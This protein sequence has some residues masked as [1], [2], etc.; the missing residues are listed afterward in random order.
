[1]SRI[2]ILVNSVYQL[3]TA[4]HL[5]C[6]L[7]SDTHADILL[8]DVLPDA[9]ARIL[10][11]QE[12]ALFSRVLY[13]SSASFNA[14]Y[15]NASK[16][17]LDEVFLQPLTTLNTLISEPLTSYDSIFFSNFDPFL[18][19]IA[20]VYYSA[21]C[22]FFC[23]E[24]GF[25]S[26]V[27]SFLNPKR[28][29]I[30]THPQAMKISEKLRAFYLFE[31][32]LAMRGDSV[33]NR[34]IPKID[35]QNHSFVALLN[36]IFSYTPPP[37]FPDFL[38]LEQSFRAERIQTNDAELMAMCKQFASPR[39]FFIKPHPRCEDDMFY[40]ARLFSGSAP[41]ELY[42]LNG[43]YRHTTLLTVCSNGALSGRIALGM[44][45]EIVLLYKLF[46]GKV[47][48]KEDDVLKRYLHAFSR[49][50]PDAHCY[51][52]NTSHELEDI[53]RVLGGN[54]E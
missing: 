13:A 40:P 6:T 15:A 4:V 12:S 44:Q 45:N 23:Y 47:L 9:R 26:Y 21:P 11:L 22:D 5:K 17:S 30:N 50:F 54:N 42:L 29:V 27:I 52:P 32:T 3:L 25:S 39:R 28:A 24:D 43:M 19:L 8:T 38:F 7:L 31:P 10:P 49:R 35:P 33:A 51:V 20:C 37:S 16:Q 41:I 34:R 1:M 18:R 36:R 2:L 14:Q 53:L 48:W 46:S